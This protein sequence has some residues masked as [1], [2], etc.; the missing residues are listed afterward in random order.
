[1]AGQ[2]WLNA[3]AGLVS[4]A[5]A[6]RDLDVAR[7]LGR[8]YTEE[9]RQLLREHQSQLA[10]VQRTEALNQV[11]KAG[12]VG[13]LVAAWAVPP[14]W[15]LAMVASFR[16]FPHTSRRLLLSVLA[17]GG[18]TVVGSGVLLHQV[19]ESASAP[20]VVLPAAQSAER[21]STP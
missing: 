4:R 19:L 11:A 10:R 7:R 2:G 8:W 3:V 18:A 5:E 13:L 20:P 17:V 6:E 15:P 21:A 16:N 14:L 9:D 1:M 12:T